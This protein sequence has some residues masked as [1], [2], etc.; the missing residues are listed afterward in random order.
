LD[1]MSHRGI[2]T[3]EEGGEYVSIN[4][5]D[6]AKES[7]LF[8]CSLFWPYIDSYWL[9]LNTMRSLL[10]DIV[11]EES[12][13]LNR[14]RTFG[15]IMYYDGELNY[16]EAISSEPLTNALTLF[17]ELKV[18]RN[19]RCHFS[20]PY[21]TQHNTTQHATLTLKF[22]RVFQS[23]V[24]TIKLRKD[25]DETK[26]NALIDRIGW[27]RRD[28]FRGLRDSVVESSDTEAELRKKRFPKA[29]AKM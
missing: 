21:T 16:I 7:F 9:V 20:L 25:Y 14:T 17:N 29:L 5:S 8:L 6:S 11:V 2:L 23:K 10:P 18:T 24:T 22:I 15:L 1:Q 3:L 4:T 19:E 26:L 28:T 13:F 27:Y 12:N